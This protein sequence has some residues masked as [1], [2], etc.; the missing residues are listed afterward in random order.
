MSRRKRNVPIQQQSTSRFSSKKEEITNGE[1]H[2][3]SVTQLWTLPRAALLLVTPI[4]ASTVL[5]VSPRY[6]E[7]LYGNVFSYLYFKEAALGSVIFGIILGVWVTSIAKKSWARQDDKQNE[8]YLSTLIMTGIDWCGILLALSP[9][10]VKL[11]FTQ[12]GTLGPYL[13]PHITQTWLAY[14]VLFTLALINT[15]VCA[16]REREKNILLYRWAVYVI[17]HIVVISSLTYVLYNVVAMGRTC[18]RLYSGGLLLALVGGLFKALFRIYGEITLLED[19][20]QRRKAQALKAKNAKEV[21]PFVSTVPQIFII[22]LVI[23]NAGFNPQCLLNVINNNNGQNNSK[24]AYIILARNESVTGWID[25][26]DDPTRDIRI[27]RAGHS[28]IGGVHKSTWESVFA[29]FYYMEAVQL[30][31]GRTH[32]EQEKALQIGLGIGVSASSLQE[33]NVLVDIVEIDPVV[34][35]F[36]VNYF[37]LAPLNKPHIQDGRKFINEASANKYDYVLHDVFTGGSVPAALFSIEALIQIQRILKEDGVLALNYVGSQKW[38]DAE[39]L[40]LVYNTIKAVF[41]YVNCY[42]EGSNESIEVFENLVFFASA[43]P[44][45]F[46]AITTNSTHTGGLREYILETF[47]KWK[48][49]LTRLSNI[50]GV[51]TD[52]ENPLNKLQLSSAFDHWHIMRELFPLEFWLDY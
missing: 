1:D 47:E 49:D 28:L 46:R 20:A 16:R 44:I 34:Y 22:L 10:S 40:G 30:V 41:P 13:G 35:A 8:A 38:P 3:T 14:P 52:H 51:I 19:S 37:R 15:L 23:Y 45:S 21:R 27:M 26:V 39:A 11:L 18:Q 48:V 7:P 36:A 50:T 4:L 29:S 33:N 17:M 42:R 25:I 6:L 43:K 9:L 32:D 5:Q 12:S 31:E 24:S 2:I